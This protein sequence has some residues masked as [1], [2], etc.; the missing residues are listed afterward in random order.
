MDRSIVSLYEGLRADDLLFAEKGAMVGLAKLAEAVFGQ[1]TVVDGLACTPAT[2]LNVSIGPGSIYAMAAT[3]AT[4]FGTL[5]SDSNQILQQGLRAASGNLACPAPGTAGYSIN[6][7]IEAQFQAT[8]ANNIT[9]PFYDVS[10]PTVPKYQTGYTQRLGVCVVQVKAGIA[11]ATG[12]QTTPAADTGW[13]PL[14]VVTVANGASSITTGNISVHPSAPFISVRNTDLGG[15]LSALTDVGAINTLVANPAPALTVLRAGMEVSVVPA[16]TNT[17][18]TTFNLNGLGAK[19]VVN[20]DGSA[21]NAG[22]IVAGRL[23]VFYY[24]TSGQFVY[25]NPPPQPIAAITASGTA[26]ALTI[27]PSPAISTYVAG[28]EFDVIATNT[29]TGPATVA[30]NGLAAKSIVN[31]DSSALAAGEI[32][33]GYVLQ[34]AYNGS[35]FVFVNAPQVATRPPADSSNF[36]ASTAYADAAAAAAAAAVGASGLFV[37]QQQGI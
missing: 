11:A 6:Y 9:L 10:N 20:A 21:L 28:L 7:L 4:A 22:Q 37:W 29:N 36:P 34:L 27:S 8:D 18:A 5:P 13:T 17:G 12:T 32:V 15:L 35:A 33:A 1:N 24:S 25:A 26:N 16:V 30:V 2:G 23:A 31:P 3:D 19:S 14:W